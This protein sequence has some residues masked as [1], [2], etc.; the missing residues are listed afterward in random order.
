MLKVVMAVAMVVVGLVGA[1]VATPAFGDGS[2]AVNATVSASAPCL[3]VNTT[4]LVFPTQKFSTNSLNGISAISN[5]PAVMNCSGQTASI[6][7]SGSDATGPNSSPTWLLT[8]VTLPQT[9]CGGS[10]ELRTINKFAL[11]LRFSDAE[12][13]LSKLGVALKSVANGANLPAYDLE[14]FMPCTTSDGA[15]T[16]MSFQ[17]TFT[18]SLP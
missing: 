6:I 3:T 18:A 9:V 8:P 2:G 12:P 5:G 1:T 13:T 17:I 10:G 11:G 4:P 7:G 15:G 14:L 16:V